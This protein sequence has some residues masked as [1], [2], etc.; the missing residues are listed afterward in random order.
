[1][2]LPKSMKPITLILAGCV[3]ISAVVVGVLQFRPNPA[4]EQVRRSASQRG[5]SKLDQIIWDYQEAAR[6]EPRDANARAVLGLAYIQ[7]ARE[8]ADPSYYAKAEHVLNEALRINPQHIEALV[9]EGSLALSRHQFRE[10]LAIGEKARAISPRVPR[11]YG[12]IADAQIE[13]GM[14]DQAVETIQT[15]VDMRPDL[16]SYSRVAYIRELNGDLDGAIEAMNQA[17]QAGGPALE[18]VEWTRVQLGNLYAAKGDLDAAEQIYRLSLSH[19]PQYVYALAGLAHVQAARG[20]YNQAATLYQQAIA[21]V[22][23]PECVIALGELYQAQGKQAEADQQYQLVRAM[24][25]LFQSAGVD[26][27]LELALFEADHGTHPDATVTLARAAYERRPNIKGA[28]TL[29]WA[30]YQAGNYAEARSY[31]NLALHLGTQDA[32][33]LYHAGMIAKSQGD[34]NAA[35]DWLNAAL[36]LNPSFS[37]LYAPEARNALNA[38]NAAAGMER[39]SARTQERK[40]ARAMERWNIEIIR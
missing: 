29:A 39:K 9:G 5:V 37:P 33:I 27:D 31:A 12:V 34:R 30:L 7:K 28:D 40:N 18:N 21:L 2:R 4:A 17:V 13:L 16:S 3:L 6:R 22:P 15:M 11:I 24:Q 14:Y 20:E 36:T 8:T 32:T 1:M 19:N 35:R 38:V 25:Q 26:T 10:A 23:L